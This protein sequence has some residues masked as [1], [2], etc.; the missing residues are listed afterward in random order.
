[1]KLLIVT[2]VVDTEHPILGFFHRWVIEFAKHVE[3][4]HV[5]ALQ[6]GKY[7]LPEN[8]HLHSLGKEEG[9]GKFSYVLRFYKYIWKYRK[10]YDHVF[11]HMSAE[12]VVLAGWLWRLLEEGGVVVYA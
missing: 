10:E 6:V 12:Y 4:L 1:M 11:V 5:I 7:D 2:Q 8:V 3:E 9:V